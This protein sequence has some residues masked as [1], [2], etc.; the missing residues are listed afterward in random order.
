M[1]EQEI[2]S[3]Q[4]IKKRMFIPPK[5]SQNEVQESLK[6]MRQKRLSRVN[7]HVADQTRLFEMRSEGSDQDS[8]DSQNDINCTKISENKEVN[9]IRTENGKNVVEETIKKIPK[10]KFLNKFNC[11]VNQVDLSSSNED[12]TKDGETMSKENLNSANTS[13]VSSANENI[14]YPQNTIQKLSQRKPIYFPDKFVLDSVPKENIQSTLVVNNT[15]PGFNQD[16]SIVSTNK[17]IP[18]KPI[19]DVQIKPSVISKQTVKFGTNKTDEFKLKH[20]SNVDSNSFRDQSQKTLNLS[21]EEKVLKKLQLNYA[22]VKNFVNNESDENEVDSDEME[23]F[24]NTLRDSKK[25]IADYEDNIAKLAEKLPLRKLKNIKKGITEIRG[26]IEK[27]RG[28]RRDFLYMD[29]SKR[30]S[31]YEKEL[32]KLPN[33]VK[34]KQEFVEYNKLCSI[35]LEDKVKNNEILLNNLLNDLVYVIA[36]RK[37]NETLL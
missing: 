9:V 32:L 37:N 34:Q 14:V 4:L 12:L 26:H 36:L 16:K 1:G 25:V 20:F 24:E 3:P 35:L 30:L 15:L 7:A 11:A 8:C 5:V 10:R 22:T 13:N 33:K 27:F 2:K 28:L 29:L 17:E 21:R 6:A 19:E 18:I 23:D 31:A